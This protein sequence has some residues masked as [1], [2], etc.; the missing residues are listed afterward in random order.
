[1]RA[2]IAMRFHPALASG[3]RIRYNG[4]PIE[5]LPEPPLQDVIERQIQLSGGRSAH[6]RAGILTGLSPLN[7]VH[8]GFRHRIIMP[9]CG[10]GCG[11]Y[12]G[13]NKIFVRIYLAGPW[14]LGQFKD[15]LPDDT[16]REELDATAH[17]ILQPLLAQWQDAALSI[18]WKRPRQRSTRCCR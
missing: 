4:Q 16:E 2:Q 12:S 14:H 8:V 18:V 13:L 3:V 6:I 9:S 10:L 17:E 15:D 7:R 1:M 5:V 11:T